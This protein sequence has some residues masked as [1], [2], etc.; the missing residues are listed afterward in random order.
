MA[1]RIIAI[2]SFIQLLLKLLGSTGCPVHSLRPVSLGGA[3]CNRLV[4]N[5][6]SVY[7]AFKGVDLHSLSL[8]TLV[9]FQLLLEVLESWLGTE[10]E[11]HRKLAIQ[12]FSTHGCM[13]ACMPF[14][15][16]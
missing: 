13:T 10:R 9:N 3:A 6:I 14:G 16:L 8:F 15:L 7:S 5:H 4:G 2:N 1:T 11:H 12:D